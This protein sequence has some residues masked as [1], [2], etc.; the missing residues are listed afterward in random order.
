VG[1]DE[2]R[3]EDYL[4]RFASKLLGFL[5]LVLLAGTAAADQLALL[6]QGG[7]TVG[8][9][10]AQRRDTVFLADGRPVAY[11]SSGSVYGFNGTHLGWVEN[12]VV[13]SHSGEAMGTV[14]APEDSKALLAGIKPGSYAAP[15]RLMR[16]IEPLKP[17]FQAG[18]SQQSL[19]QLLAQ[20]TYN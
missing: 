16:D 7:K 3:L 6:D 4:K 12:G 13:W 20:G 1:I 8:Y 11:L 19:E 2:L 10:D 17:E 15:R 9:V 14:H 5:A 18:S